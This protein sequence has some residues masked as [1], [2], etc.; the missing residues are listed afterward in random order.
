MLGTFYKH[1]SFG[2]GLAD[3][4][5]YAILYLTTIIHLILILTT[6]AKGQKRL[7]VIVILVTLFICLKATLWRGSEYRWNG[8][9]FYEPPKGGINFDKK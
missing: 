6:E 3:Y 7:S 4:F 9:L 1:I 5:G 8:H 2:W